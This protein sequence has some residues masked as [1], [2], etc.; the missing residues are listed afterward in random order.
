[1]E[2][3]MEHVTQLQLVFSDWK[4]KQMKQFTH[5]PSRTN[6]INGGLTQLIV[7]WLVPSSVIYERA[8]GPSHTRRTIRFQAAP[9]ARRL[10]GGW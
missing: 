7:I 9:I 5:E 2:K 4:N 6:N 1:M 10:W 3:S 8:G